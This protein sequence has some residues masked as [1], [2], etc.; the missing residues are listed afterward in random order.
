MMKRFWKGG[1]MYTIF[2]LATAV[3]GMQI[4]GSGFWAVIDFFFAPFAWLKWLIYKEVSI[5]IIAKAF[6]FFFK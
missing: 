2:S 3:V 5:S 1:V 6:E 4:H